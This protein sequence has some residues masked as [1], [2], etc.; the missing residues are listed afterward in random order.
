VTKGKDSKKES[1]K[2]KTTKSKDNLKV[3]PWYENS[4]SQGADVGKRKTK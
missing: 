4:P 2:P 3:A 1:K